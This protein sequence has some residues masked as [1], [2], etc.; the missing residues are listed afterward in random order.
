MTAMILTPCPY[1]CTA[2]PYVCHLPPRIFRPADS[3]QVLCP[4]CGAF[5]PVCSSPE[6]AASAWRAMAGRLRAQN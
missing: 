2:S 5:G 3:Y 1:G 4:T 6:E